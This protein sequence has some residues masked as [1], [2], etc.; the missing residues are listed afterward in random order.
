MKL[1][2]DLLWPLGEG[3][4]GRDCGQF[5]ST[6]W[7]TVPVVCQFAIVEG[8]WRPSMTFVRGFQCK[9]ILLTQMVRWVDGVVGRK[10]QFIVWSSAIRIICRWEQSK[11]A[12]QFPAGV[13]GCFQCPTANLASVNCATILAI[14]YLG[15]KSALLD[16]GGRYHSGMAGPWQLCHRM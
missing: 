14:A 15:M 10:C 13:T 11:Y 3:W 9:R 5:T 6:L 12:P 4:L 16:R 1:P 8:E 2:S 7:H